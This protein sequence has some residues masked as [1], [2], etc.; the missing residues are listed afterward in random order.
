MDAPSKS[1][2]EDAFSKFIAK[3]KHDLQPRPAIIEHHARIRMPA[4]FEPL[5]KFLEE[6]QERAAK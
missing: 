5:A 6:K 4:G 2:M 3:W 1:P